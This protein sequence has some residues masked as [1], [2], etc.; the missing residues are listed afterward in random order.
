[1][2]EQSSVCGYLGD[3]DPVWCPGCGNYGILS[4]FIEALNDLNLATNELALISG[5]GCSSRLPYFVKA[6]GFHGIHGRTLPIA[7]GVKVANP[8][9]TVI[10]VAGD[11]DGLAIGGGHLPHVARNNVDLTYLLFNNA[12]YGMT[13]G[14]F[15]PTTLLAPITK[16]SP[17]GLPGEPVNPS[18]LAIVYGA[19]FVARGFS[20]RKEHLKDLIIQGIRHP[21]FSFIEILTSCAAFNTTDMNVARIVKNLELVPKDHDP[22]VATEALKLATAGDK[23][24]VGILRRDQHPTLGDKFEETANQMSKKKPVS[25]DN[26]LQ[27]FA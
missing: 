25:I 20:V 27:Q 4:G 12:I 14:Q 3:V 18:A 8:E 5:I 9:L 21:G 6:Y 2:E 26:L 15:S 23:I 1:M 16:T 13:K 22:T 7:Q 19:T 24:Y 17:F 10:G 11:G